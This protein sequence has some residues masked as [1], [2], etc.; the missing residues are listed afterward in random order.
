MTK[1]ILVSVAAVAV[2]SVS[3]TGCLGGSGSPEAPKHAQQDV[4]KVEVIKLNIPIAGIDDVNEKLKYLSQAYKVSMIASNAVFASEDLNILIKNNAGK[5]EKLSAEIADESEEV[6]E[7]KLIAF[8]DEFEAK[9]EYKS[10]LDN[11]KIK[12]AKA[13]EDVKKLGLDA[14]KDFIAKKLDS[15]KI[16]ADP[17]ISSMGFM[18]KAKIGN[19]I[20][21]LPKIIKQITVTT[22]N[23]AEITK[24]GATETYKSGED[25]SVYIT[26]SLQNSLRNDLSES[27]SVDQ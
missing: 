10:A 4:S 23:M 22:T 12:Y 13:Q 17:K 3:F 19:E 11:L 20:S 14:L 21:K 1:K 18:D 25:L 16:M 15:K 9:P 5:I 8:L 27:E 2:L 24:K 6:Q 26:N 7:K